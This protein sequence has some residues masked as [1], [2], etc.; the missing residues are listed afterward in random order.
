MAMLLG[1]SSA[2]KTNKL[3]KMF[4]LVL[5]IARFHFEQINC[6][7]ID[8]FETRYVDKKG[9]FYRTGQAGVEAKPPKPVG[10]KIVPRETEEDE[11]NPFE[12]TIAEDTELE[13]EYRKSPKKKDPIAE[14]LDDG[15]DGDTAAKLKLTNQQLSKIRTEFRT[16]GANPGD[17]L[18]AQNRFFVRDVSQ[19]KLNTLY[20]RQNVLNR[21][22][23]IT[24]DLV[25]SV[26]KHPIGLIYNE[27][28][29]VLKTLG[30]KK[31]TFYPNQQY[32]CD[33]K[34]SERVEVERQTSESGVGPKSGASII[35][36]LT[37]G[38]FLKFLL[39]ELADTEGL[40]PRFLLLYLHS[41]S[42]D[43]EQDPTATGLAEDEGDDDA[44][45]S[46]VEIQFV[47]LVYAI[48]VNEVSKSPGHFENDSPVAG[49]SP[50]ALPVLD[51]SGVSDSM[52]QS[53]TALKR[54]PL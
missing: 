51:Y 8:K 54:R 29:S 23:S 9:R 18:K 10:Y 25:K 19:A 3:L 13:Y 15:D 53:L 48:V 38:V 5:D 24:G 39:E 41:P 52:S 2:G 44:I 16:L 12:G 40:L 1:K 46:G 45:Q 7:D 43:Y 30:A 6:E 17:F 36:A 47:L 11:V 37:D 33:R 21:V 49:M 31:E 28:G 42:E 26:Y 34:D 50:K 20:I 32:L 27:F 14:A 35:G 22:A 4:N